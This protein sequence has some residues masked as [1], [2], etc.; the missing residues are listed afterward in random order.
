MSDLLKLAQLIIA[1]Y[2]RREKSW[3]D[4]IELR[5]G[6]YTVDQWDAI[7]DE[8]KDRGLPDSFQVPAQLLL[9]WPN[10]SL[11]WAKVQIA[12]GKT[13]CEASADTAALAELH[14]HI[15]AGGFVQEYRP[16]QGHP[17]LIA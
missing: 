12:Q 15:E 13:N 1:A 16:V 14:A 9:S 2:D 7:A 5:H 10:D 11:E 3:V 6:Q 8:I 4:G 17:I